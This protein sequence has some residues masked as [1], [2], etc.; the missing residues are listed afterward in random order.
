MKKD[1][2]YRQ[3]G[4]CL[5]EILL[6]TFK[7]KKICWSFFF[8]LLGLVIGIFSNLSIPFLLKKIVEHFSSENSLSITLILLSYGLIWMISQASSHIRALLTYKIEQR[9]TFHLGIKVLSH[10]YSLSH[11]YFLN[12]KPGALTN[13]IRRAQQDVPSIILGLFFHVLPTVLE[14]LFVVILLS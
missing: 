3:Y 7:D 6:L 13:M 5:K 9:I 11:S 4:H 10:F 8:S 2:P 14:F 12:Q 1:I